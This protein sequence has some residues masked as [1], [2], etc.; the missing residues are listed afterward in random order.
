[1]TEDE[2]FEGMINGTFDTHRLHDAA[3]MMRCNISEHDGDEILKAFDAGES[4]LFL[5][6]PTPLSD[7]EPPLNCFMC[8]LK[9]GAMISDIVSDSDDLLAHEW[10]EVPIPDPA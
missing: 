4:W 5:V 7:D 10:P 9:K 8:S 3:S 1:M 6:G 2:I